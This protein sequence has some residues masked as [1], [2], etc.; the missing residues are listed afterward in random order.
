MKGST[1]KKTLPSGKIKWGYSI[2]VGKDENGVRKRLYNCT[3]EREKDADA[4][5]ARVLGEKGLSG[6]LTKPDAQTFGAFVEMWLREYGPRNCSLKTL[7]RYGELIAYILPHVGAVRLQDLDALRLE[8]A[9]LLVQKSGGVNRKTKKKQALALS[10]AFIHIP[11]VA[12]TILNRAVKLKL[13]PSSPMAGVDLPSVPDTEAQSLSGDQVRVFVNEA[14]ASGFY[15]FLM[16][17]VSV[18]CR[19]GET[20]A[21]TWP[22]LDLVKRTARISKSVEQTR[23]LAKQNKNSTDP[24]LR[25][26]LRLKGTKVNRTR[27]VSLSVPMVEILK[28]HRERQ[29]EFRREFKNEY[30]TDLDLVFGDETGFYLKPNDVSSVVCR[31]A[32]R[33]GFEKRISLH[34]L[35]HSHATQL[36]AAGV[37]IATVS[38]RLGHTSPL[39]TAKIYQHSL[40]ADD[41]AAAEL[42]EAKFQ[43]S[44]ATSPN[45]KIC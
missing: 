16:F 12:K 41:S 14:H 9:F 35:R 43:E 1:F 19:R 24:R 3:F 33:A 25:W 20:C 36:L 4:A 15:E 42:W 28:M 8:R 23:T 31:I 13:I 17:A 29:E 38:K 18:G 11:A 30:R 44:A 22:D 45:A 32:H 21:V 40:P 2:D 37:P 7:E 39:T 27:N 10:T 6:D 5:L 26:G 34:T